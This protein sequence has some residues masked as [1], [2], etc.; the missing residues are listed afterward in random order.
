MG[1][2]REEISMQNAEQIPDEDLRFASSKMKPLTWLPQR[3]SARSEPVK[4]LCLER[5]GLQPVR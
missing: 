1:C 4:K 2:K 5:Y 3:C